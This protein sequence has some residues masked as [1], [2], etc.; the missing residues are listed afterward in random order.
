[1]QIQKIQWIKKENKQTKSR[2]KISYIVNIIPK[3][4][5]ILQGLP[6]EAKKKVTLKEY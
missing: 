5:F 3:P 2:G 4:K 1:M 6:T